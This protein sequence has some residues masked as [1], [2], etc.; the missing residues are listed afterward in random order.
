MKKFFYWSSLAMA[1]MLLVNCAKAQSAF[2]LEQDTVWYFTQGTP[3]TPT[4]EQ[5]FLYN[6]I[7]NQTQENWTYDWRILTVDFPEGWQLYGF[8]DNL[9]C[10]PPEHPSLSAPFPS[11]KAASIETGK[12]VGMEGMIYAWII[13]PVD[14]AENGRGILTVE[15]TAKS[16]TPYTDTA[17]FILTKEQTVG[18]NTLNLFTKK[19]S[20]FP[21][22]NQGSMFLSLEQ[23][24][25]IRYVE[26]YA[27]DGRLIQRQSCVS[28]VQKLN[29]SHCRQGVYWL[30]LLDENRNL[31]AVEKIIKQ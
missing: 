16:A 24:S 17:I 10:R 1:L 13:A 29:I 18:N 12:E 5:V 31:I 15:I 7:I 2:I 4:T 26:V 30:R 3:A 23:D 22:P 11:E 19:H 14:S 8:S 6:T 27:I 20:I 25:P 28:G 9:G 21:N